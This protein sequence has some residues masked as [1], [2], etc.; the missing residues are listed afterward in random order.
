MCIFCL[1]SDTRKLHDHL[2]MTILRAA[3][4]KKRHREQYEFRTY[5]KILNFHRLTGSTLS[6]FLEYIERNLPEGVHLKATKVELL[7]LPEHLKP[8]KIDK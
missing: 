6:T 2:R 8:P 1:F 3:F 4:G 7:R 5:Y